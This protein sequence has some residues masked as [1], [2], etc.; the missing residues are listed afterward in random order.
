MGAAC[1][2]GRTYSNNE[3]ENMIRDILWNIKL[4]QSNLNTIHKAY[5]AIAVKSTTT[6]KDKD[7]IKIAI[8][9]D[10]YD[11]LLKN[12][13]YESTQT[14]NQYAKFQKAIFP[15]MKELFTYDPE[16]V[17]LCNSLSLSSGDKNFGNFKTIIN[18]FHEKLN[19]E[20]FSQF[21]FYYLTINLKEWTSRIIFVIN[22]IK[23]KTVID[24]YEI[25]EEFKEQANK[26]N[27]AYTIE[28][29][30][31]LADYVNDE[32]KSIVIKRKIN[33]SETAIRYETL[34]KEDLENLNYKLPWLF[35]AV[36][37]RRFFYETYVTTDNNVPKTL[38][39]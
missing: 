28:R 13:F 32:L 26:L 15:T 33:S 31:S 6:E 7:T 18:S 9:D 12:Y 29:V 36:E 4:R 25:N 39:K 23:T 5:E 21:I 3:V 34:T 2:T 8:R 24:Q 17:I 35:D 11:E 19:F 14:K 30:K 37:L 20:A 38:N 1:C 27:K 10:K 22:E 16:Y